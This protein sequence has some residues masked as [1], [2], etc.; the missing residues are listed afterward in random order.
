LKI[1]I[2]I[3]SGKAIVGNMGYNKAIGLTAIGDVVNTASRL[4]SLT[5][6]HKVQM[7]V[8][9]ETVQISQIEFFS[10]SAKNVS[11]RGRVDPI[12]VYAISDASQLNT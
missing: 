3:H 2:G 6:E 12:E 11:I 4:E 8:S 9:S 7:I 1:G 10:Q 5:K